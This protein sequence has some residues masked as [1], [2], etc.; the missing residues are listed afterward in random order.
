[1]QRFKWWQCGLIGGV[2]LSLVTVLHIVFSLP[3][4]ISHK[5]PW[6]GLVA[7]PLA[8]LAAG[9]GCGVIVWVA[10][11]LSR[12]L[13]MLGDAIVGMLTLVF[14]FLACMVLFDRSLLSPDPR[15]SLPMFGL[16][17]VGGAIAGAWFGRD[18]RKDRERREFYA[19]AY[20]RHATAADLD[21]IEQAL[22]VKLP[23]DYRQLLLDYPFAENS[24][25]DSML[26]CNPELLLVLNSQRDLHFQIHHRKGRWVP[27]KNHF[28][29]GNDGGEEQFYLDLNEAGCTVL[30]FDLE[31]GELSPF[32]NSA[33]E[34]KAK[35]NEIDRE[36]E[37]E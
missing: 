25:A 16:A 19:E 17:A 29:I 2:A 26:I 1:M 7:V 31:T 23:A 27:G 22:S 10:A 8:V 3:D 28:M 15:R 18:W 5:I 24:V 35:V 6:S 13:G 34:F 20:R 21:G 36:C 9:F 11:P 30:K 33:A 32:A 14:F 4:F 37:A 12:K